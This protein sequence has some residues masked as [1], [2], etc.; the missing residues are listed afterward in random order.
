M[1]DSLTGLLIGNIHILFHTLIILCIN[2][3]LNI[4]IASP[5]TT[6]L[7]R[8]RRICSFEAVMDC[9][10]SSGEISDKCA[11][12]IV[13][14]FMVNLNNDVFPV[15]SLV[16]GCR[17]IVECLR[18][19]RCAN[20]KM[21]DLLPKLMQLLS[22]CGHCPEGSS[23]FE[24]GMTSGHSYRDH[25]IHSICG[26]H[27]DS[28]FIVPLCACFKEIDMSSSQL[29]LF[30]RKACL[31][32]DNLTLNELPSLVYHLYVFSKKGQREF[33]LDA[34][35]DFMYKQS[36]AMK[37]ETVTANGRKR[38]NQL[39]AVQGTIILHTVNAMKQDQSL[40][41]DFL[42]LM[43]TRPASRLHHIH[44]AV[45]F[46]M[47]KIYHFETLAADCIKHI[48]LKTFKRSE[49]TRKRKWIK[50]CMDSFENLVESTFMG[51]AEISTSGW[52]QVTE[53]LIKVCFML[54]DASVAG[55]Y[56]KKSMVSLD[57]PC[58][59]PMESMRNLA[60]NLIISTFEKQEIVRSEVMSQIFSRILAKSSDNVFPVLLN[61]LWV[62]CP[63]GITE[64]IEQVRDI[65]DYLC[66]LPTDISG[67]VL[68][69]IVPALCGDLAML[70]ALLV[71]LKKG[72]FNRDLTVRRNALTGYLCIFMAI[73]N[74]SK[75][76]LC[77]NAD[78]LLLEITGV[79]KRC[80]NQQT[81]LK[82]QFYESL[83]TCTEAS[84]DV[85][86]Y[87]FDILHSRF[88]RYVDDVS[89]TQFPFKIKECIKNN[90]ISEPLGYLIASLGRLSKLIKQLDR[91]S[92][93]SKVEVFTSVMESYSRRL[94]TC[95]LSQLDLGLF[96]ASGKLCVTDL[97]RS[98]Y[99]A[100]IEYQ[101]DQGVNQDVA[102]I[103]SGLMDKLASEELLSDEKLLKAKQERQRIMDLSSSQKLLSICLSKQR[104]NVLLREIIAKNDI[105]ESVIV[106][107]VLAGI[108]REQS[109]KSQLT[110]TEFASIRALFKVLRAWIYRSSENDSPSKDELEMK[111]FKFIEIL[112]HCLDVLVKRAP[113]KLME[114]L[115][116]TSA[117]MSDEDS[118]D[119][120]LPFFFEITSLI[121]IAFVKDAKSLMKP[122]AH[123][124]SHLSTVIENFTICESD[125]KQMCQGIIEIYREYKTDDVS[126]VKNLTH[127]LV[128]LQ[129]HTGSWKS[130]NFL[131]DDCK[132]VLGTYDVAENEPSQMAVSLNMCHMKTANAMISA[133]I[134]CVCQYLDD[135]EWIQTQSNTTC[136]GDDGEN[137]QDNDY[138]AN[139]ETSVMKHMNELVKVM[140]IL[141]S[142]CL[143]EHIE[144]I[145]NCTIRIYRLLAKTLK[146]KSADRDNIHRQLVDVIA[147]V[148]TQLTP[149]V[150]GFISFTQ[151]QDIER[152]RQTG[153][154]RKKK[155]KNNAGTLI[156][157]RIDKKNKLIPNLVYEIEQ[158][159][160]WLIRLSKKANINL[161]K[162]CKRS[163]TRD[164]K[165]TIEDIPADDSP[166]ESDE[167]ED[168]N[169]KQAKK[170]KT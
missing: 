60:M 9:F 77:I 169:L 100:F 113:S 91:E 164:F 58:A 52:D 90:E 85:M 95:N 45:M 24:E 42:K 145:F 108:I 157:V 72:I 151:A 71:V 83:A 10:K 102:E 74:A 30:L 150:Y 114:T 149:G 67:S 15:K 37:P 73:Q 59:N 110:S 98:V 142:I 134:V 39:L 144:G 68:N 14:M 87:A 120:I 106:D 40:G 18:E 126:F 115:R 7:G 82:I 160:N 96:N 64:N 54:V 53:G 135:F 116:N 17:A 78:D 121:K 153:P 161:T 127:V 33:V 104:N 159:E 80:L 56:S 35:M 93:N 29:R 22:Y 57:A 47:T 11:G 63:Q 13:N 163:T 69:I 101:I 124:L 103:I 109:L 2:T 139:I 118:S 27:W 19:R 111:W 162:Y 165:I 92:T 8:K 6:E 166:A 158:Y 79:M 89:T 170:L 48:L 32:F 117:S 137:H 76:K 133:I 66:F 5:E 155:S 154:T 119:L 61:E 46:S 12:Q 49:K 122:L 167:N 28:Q 20:V 81:D 148:S 1:A 62:Q 99:E 105:V 138:I 43:K 136:D 75:R 132:K 130:V 97:L 107:S 147:V 88:S 129:N 3:Y 55:I 146:S 34:V 38:Y 16:Y 143:N 141:E 31:H 131:V 125:A 4:S 152:A 156:K 50:D 26:W 86:V 44:V 84:V 112:Y 25:L 70:N 128:T 65:L 21:F 123:L 23:V 140:V 36:E 51:V 94:S 168:E 41:T